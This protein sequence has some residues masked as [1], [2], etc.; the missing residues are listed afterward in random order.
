MVV[1]P[2]R[3]RY[4]TTRHTA[5]V[6]EP[7]WSGSDMNVSGVPGVGND[8]PMIEEVIAIPPANAGHAGV[9]SL[10]PMARRS[11][12]SSSPRNYRRPPDGGINS[13]LSP[14]PF[15]SSLPPAPG[16]P[17]SAAYRGHSQGGS[18]VAGAVSMY[19]PRRNNFLRPGSAPGAKGP[20]VNL[21]TPSEEMLSAPGMQTALTT[22]DAGRRPAAEELQ[23]ELSVTAAVLRA[24][25]DRLA[26]EREQ[27]QL[28]RVGEELALID[29][30]I[31]RVQ[32]PH[33][34]LSL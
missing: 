7:A 22:H 25:Q 14:R 11:G 15:S 30:R 17:S 27:R 16:R 5:R 24:A 8:G 19:Q 34:Q 28:A 18:S 12:G 23:Y 20:L 32:C 2:P 10:N 26:K 13:S 33:V 31:F 4:N 21:M 9:G 29:V 3:S 6:V 1:L